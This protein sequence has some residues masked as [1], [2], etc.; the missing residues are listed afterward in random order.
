MAALTKLAPDDLV[1]R[2]VAL[3]GPDAVRT[4]AESC[5]FYTQDV[6]SRGPRALAVV[7]PGDTASLAAAVRLATDA[8]VVVV[9]RGGGM[10]YTSGYVP[11][12]AGAVMVDLTAMDRILAIDPVDMTVTVE[13]GCTWAKLHEALK[14]LKLRPPFWGTLSGR[15]AT[16]GGGMSQNGVFWG[17]RHGAATDSAIRFDVVL[18]DGSVAGTGSAFFR[19]FG[20]DLTGVFAADTG[21]L[22]IKATVTLRLV[23]E[24]AHCGFASF[25]FPTAQA[26]LGA[27]S[28]VAREGLASE[29]FAFDPFL[30]SQR[31]KRESLGSDARALLGVMRAQG[32]LLGALK[33]GAKVVV[34]GRGFLD[35]VPYSAHFTTE[36]RTRRSAEDDRAEIVRLAVAHGGSEVD[37][38][39]P[40]VMRA[41]PFGPVNS[42]LG[43]DGERWVPVHGIVPHSRA[44]AT[45]AAILALYDAHAAAMAEHAIGAGYMFVAVGTTGMLIEPVFFWPDA[46]EALHRASVEPAHLARLKGFP[47]N[48][49]ARQLV[50]TLRHGVIA[51]FAAV[52]AVHF[53]IGRTYPYTA[54]L[55]PGALALM[56]AIKRHVDPRGLMNPGSLGL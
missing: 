13:A 43:P 4:D 19:P 54:S 7:R 16:I 18:A 55:D 15:Y 30:Q 24:A 32:S 20:P 3:L 42:M 37:A 46:T 50:E 51:L 5:D 34:A 28:D 49:A 36:G 9:P 38:T 14:P 35:G 21:A 29:A 10:S 52:P 41:N 1:A 22:G 12:D 48:P 26:V 56:R 31:M 39:I 23:R 53:Q 27:L 40:K 8:G 44:A 2:L 25:S 17:A 33:E 47:A 6:F 11:R 45:V